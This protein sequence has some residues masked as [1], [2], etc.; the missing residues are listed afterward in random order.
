MD[1]LWKDVHYAL[2][3]LRRTPGFAVA[4][5]VTVALGI[6]AKIAFAAEPA[7]SPHRARR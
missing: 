6:G 1:A 4:A 3:S 2:R 7:S 5:L